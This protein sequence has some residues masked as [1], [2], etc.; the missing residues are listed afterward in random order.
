MNCLR[1][2]RPRCSKHTLK[3][4]EVEFSWIDPLTKDNTAKIAL[5][6]PTNLDVLCFSNQ[7]PMILKVRRLIYSSMAISDHA[8]PRI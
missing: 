4:L 1:I 7:Q 5:P 3:S 2:R 8:R 6:V